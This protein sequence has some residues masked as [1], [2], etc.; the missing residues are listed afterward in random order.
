M[1]RALLI[2]ASLS[3]CTLGVTATHPD[4]KPT[5]NICASARDP[6]CMAMFADL[7]AF[8]VGAYEWSTAQRDFNPQ[9]LTGAT[10][11]LGVLVGD[12]VGAVVW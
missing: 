2:A 11:M 4:L 5:G 8:T 1:I 12:A 9:Y 10:L 7:A 6:R 3:A